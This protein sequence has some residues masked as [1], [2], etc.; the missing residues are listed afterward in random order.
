MIIKY[1]LAKT[2]IIKSKLPDTDYVI[3]PYTGCGF[4]CKYCYASFMSKF[5]GEDIKDWGN[6]VYVKT[7]ATKLADKEIKKINKKN[8]N[9]KILL[10]SVT[11]AWQGVESKY[12]LTR[13]I[14]SV[15]IKNNFQGKLSCLTKSP[16]IERDIDLLKQFKNHDIGI[17]I[18][19]MEDKVSRFLE[20]K[21]PDVSR[22]LKTLKKL[23]RAGLKTHAFVG[24]VFPHFINDLKGLDK[25]FKVIKETGTKDVYV[26][27]LNLS[28]SVVMRMIPF[29]KT[30]DKD[31]YELYTKKYK[32]PRYKKILNNAIMDIISKYKMNLRLGR[33]IEH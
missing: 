26:E 19:S 25:L 31:V 5:I 6:F 23:Y 29:L 15:L 7:N 18:T 10:S 12:K 32:D 27:H 20:T 21:A 33:I 24:P 3:N 13:G 2:I 11:D 8:P 1:K 30:C 28:S 9:A 22:R 17:T 14:L 16:L 4:A